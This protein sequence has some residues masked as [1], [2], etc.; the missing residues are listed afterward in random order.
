MCIKCIIFIEKLQKYP[1]PIENGRTV[2]AF[3]SCAGGLELKFP[4]GLILTLQTVRHRFNIY[5]VAVLSWR[6]DA[7]IGTPND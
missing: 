6:Y 2:N 3:T 5:K 7:E 1:S 4:A